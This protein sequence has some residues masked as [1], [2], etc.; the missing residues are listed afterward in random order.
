M[1]DIIQW[2]GTAGIVAFYPL[3][4]WRLA[5]TRNPVGLSF[6]AFCFLVVGIAGYL[7]LGLHLKLW[8]I[9]I[10]NSSNLFFAS[11]I[12]LIIWFRSSVLAGKE[13]AAGVSVLIAG[14]G[15]LALAHIIWS[16]EAAA[17][18]VGWVGMFGVIGFYPPQNFSLFKK[19]DPT[20]LSLAAFVSL[21]LGLVLYTVLGFMVGD[22]TLILGNGITFL[23]SLPIIAMI[24]LKKK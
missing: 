16:R 8:G 4:N 21:A 10:G 1:E 2:L 18:I 13:R 22:L 24:L 15:F 12:L 5:L 19:R 20:G 11:L 7:A 3:Q 9:V 23:G 6:L 17:S 14:I